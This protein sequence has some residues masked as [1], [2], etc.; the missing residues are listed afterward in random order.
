MNQPPGARAGTLVPYPEDF[1]A[2]YISEAAAALKLECKTP[3]STPARL[4]TAATDGGAAALSL[5]GFSS[6]G[7]SPYTNATGRAAAPAGVCYWPPGDYASKG[8]GG[9]C[10][11]PCMQYL[12]FDAAWWRNE[13]FSNGFCPCHNQVR[14]ESVALSNSSPQPRQPLC[15]P[16]SP[17]IITPPP[18]PTY[19][20][21]TNQQNKDWFADSNAP[22]A[23]DFAGRNPATGLPEDLWAAYWEAERSFAAGN[24]T[25]S[26]EPAQF[27]RL[28]PAFRVPK[29]SQSAGNTTFHVMQ[30]FWR[31]NFGNLRKPMV[32]LHR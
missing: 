24:A 1:D 10:A 26:A 32:H 9:R 16:Y 19:P 7:A 18:P 30:E 29:G 17:P 22:G 31:R 11:V 5:G 25:T 23:A 6:G 13:T 14:V 12:G 15:L 8:L 28:Q 21:T 27:Y 3:P 20:P 2:T 4:T